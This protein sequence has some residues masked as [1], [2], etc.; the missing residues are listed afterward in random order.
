MVEVPTLDESQCVYMRPE[1]VQR[2]NRIVEFFRE[3]SQPLQQQVQQEVTSE[4][5]SR[6]AKVAKTMQID[7]IRIGFVGPSQVGKSYTVAN[8]LGVAK[9]DSPTPE[10]GR[11]NATT[12]APTRIRRA[13]PGLNGDDP[14][15]TLH[16]MTRDE[17]R[18]RVS[19]ILENIDLSE[20]RPTFQDDYRKM[21]AEVSAT[22]ASIKPGDLDTHRYLVR[23]IQ[24]AINHANL[25]ASSPAARVT[26]LGDYQ[27]RRTY[28]ADEKPESSD[29]KYL[30][31]LEAVIDFRHQDPS[32]A[33]HLPE[34]LEIIDLP[35]LGTLRKC[36]DEVTRAFLPELHGAFVF[37]QSGQLTD[38]AVGTLLNVLYDQFSEQLKGRIWY[39][40]TK[41]DMLNEAGASPNGETTLHSIQKRV[42]VYGLREDTDVL[43]VGNENY[44]EFLQHG[45][46][47]REP[48]GPNDQGWRYDSDKI[49]EPLE[50]MRTPPRLG[51]LYAQ[52]LKDGGIPLFQTTATTHVRNSVKLQTQKQVDR[53]LNAFIKELERFLDS[54]VSRAGMPIKSIVACSKWAADIKK[55]REGFLRRDFSFV[56]NA[57]WELHDELDKFVVD[58]LK[59]TRIER[60]KMADSHRALAKNLMGLAIHY[61]SDPNESLVKRVFDQAVQR[62]RT[63]DRR[64]IEH[65]PIK[66][67]VEECEKRLNERQQASA[68]WTKEVFSAFQ[69]EFPDIESLHQTSTYMNVMRE[70]VAIVSRCF[71]MRLLVEIDHEVK[72]VEE[73]LEALAGNPEQIHESD[74]DLLQRLLQKVKEL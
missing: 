20:S 57:A 70:K 48:G 74:R 42:G 14:R 46:I 13:A 65:G 53:E 22:K 45:K 25:L 56:E 67:P 55:K 1:D 5:A 27:Q 51:E 73:A 21:L 18:A 6:L 64:P 58:L 15:I 24:S 47:R 69:D 37:Q 9:R 59:D 10:G 72:Q 4:L 40:V 17:F 2:Y 50:H 52:V 43:L 41:M 49:P 29:N 38:G 44:Q 16:Y 36:D 11:G 34:D 71:G 61:A 26:E 39:V 63:I 7:R 23:L 8:F 66:A 31:L 3:S 32:Q 28:V 60:S 30:L 12:S 54:A 33:K 62:L 35:G 68:H 19:K